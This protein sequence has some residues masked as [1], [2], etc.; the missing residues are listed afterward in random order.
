[1][2]KLLSGT[3][4]FV[5]VVCIN[6]YAGNTHTVDDDGPA[7]FT[8]IQDA[9]DASTDG[10][11]VT[12]ADGTYIGL[13]NRDINFNGKSIVVQS[14]NGPR[15][16]II[17]CENSNYGFLI[18][19]GESPDT[20][21]RGIQ[22]INA[23]SYG[24][25]CGGSSSPSIIDC[26]IRNCST[27]I[28]GQSC[29]VSESI[30]ENNST[31]VYG[32]DMT[33]IN[34]IIKNNKSSGISIPWGPVDIINCYISRNMGSGIFQGQGGGPCTPINMT[35]CTIT[36][37]G[38]YAILLTG[39]D[40]NVANCII[41]GHISPAI[42][43]RNHIIDIAYS[44]I[45]G[46]MTSVSDSANLI[47]GAGNIDSDPNFAFPKDY[48]I[49]PGSPCIDTG[50]TNDLNISLPQFDIDGN[51]RLLDGDNDLI[52]KV[53]MG[54]HEFNLQ[55]SCIALSTDVFDFF[56]FEGN[57]NPEDQI[58]N[59]R[60]CGGPS[61]N[62]QIQENCP[63]LSVQS[64]GGISNG[65]INTAILSVDISGMI[66]GTYQCILMVVDNLAIDSPQIVSINLI[67]NKIH[68]VPSDF[69]TIQE[70]VDAALEN[71]VIQIADGTYTGPGNVNVYINTKL[72]LRSE[73]GPQ[74]CIID[75]ENEMDTQ[76]LDIRNKVT[77]EGLTIQ[78]GNSWSG[79]AI[80]CNSPNVMIEN[81]IFINNIALEN[82]ESTGGAVYLDVE[83][84]QIDNCYFVGNQANYGGGLFCSNSS[85]SLN[86]CVFSGNTAIKLGGGI[87]CIE[88]SNLILTN[89]E[90][91]DNIAVEGG[92]I[93]AGSGDSDLGSDISNNLSL[94]NCLVQ[95]NIAW[96]FGGGLFV[97]LSGQINL[98]SCQINFNY[99]NDS[100]GGIFAA[101]GIQL[102]IENSYFEGNQ[103]YLGG[104]M[105]VEFSTNLDINNSLIAGNLADRDGGGIYCRNNSVANLRNLTIVYNRA[106][107]GGGLYGYN[108]NATA[109][110]TIFWD[111]QATS[112]PVATWKGLI[113]PS[114]LTISYSDVENNQ[115]GII[116]DSGSTLN[117]GIGNL[118]VDP[119]SVNSGQWD[120]SWWMPGDYHLRSTS[121]CI[122]NGDPLFIPLAGETDIDDQ[123][124]VN[125]VVDIGFD[126]FVL[127]GDF[128]SNY[129]VDFVDFSIFN[130]QWMLMDCTSPIWCNGCDTNHNGS[131]GNE[132]LLNFV[133]KWM[134]TNN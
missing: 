75:C 98:A 41:R 72:T 27:G 102:N 133:Q 132:D 6:S 65:E 110:N 85:P 29:M 47:W 68:N 32:M 127:T 60:S 107:E 126:E 63:W 3:V 83:E 134:S 100:G 14:E 64:N 46:G 49:M 95:D 28:Q 24:I 2:R 78:N 52:E 23:N 108:C 20:I 116:L 5:G 34:S 43:N 13:G 18:N 54:V 88:G 74:T 124:R 113:V 21:L 130:T 84:V 114:H 96:S 105:Y 25:Y 99:A 33:V 91:S 59:L 118:N 109:T 11:V 17:D 120:S 55:Q 73:N 40:A 101:D 8:T 56:A 97:D 45:E 36:N 44:N 106:G 67:V 129:T 15:N 7:D 4:L 92:G 58:L 89:C 122:D 121:P 51:S 16:C 125:N 48:H 38:F 19:S 112:G 42:R 26:I 9:I 86:N 79:S 69:L 50:T 123:I 10:D 119:L 81:C 71:D 12:V 61:I 104:G 53:D 57:D 39:C 131:V 90:I 22:I 111:N 115:N 87:F 66:S 31:G 35:N 128:N 77:I 82:G 117:W 76:G 62:W 94:Q 30:V 93:Y 37:N 80:Y 70:A 1:M 103:S